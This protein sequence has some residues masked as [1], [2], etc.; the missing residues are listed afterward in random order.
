VDNATSAL[1][2]IEQISDVRRAWLQGPVARWRSG[3]RTDGRG[4]NHN[5]SDLHWERSVRCGPL[6][7]FLI[8][9]QVDRRIN[10]HKVS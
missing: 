1:A 5:P 9:A 4:A 10:R 2:R 8:A 7:P 6:S 3:G